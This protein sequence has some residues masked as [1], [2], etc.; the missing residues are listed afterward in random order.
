MNAR[1]IAFIGNNAWYFYL[2]RIDLARALMNRGYQVTAILPSPIEGGLLDKLQSEG[3]VVFGVPY[4]PSGMNPFREIHTVW[5]IFWLIRRLQ[6]GLVHLHTIKPVLYGGIA[7]RL[8]GVPACVLS[9]LGLGHL[10][11][12]EESS[13]TIVRTAL[14]PLFRYAFGGKHSRII[15]ENTHDAKV[16]CNHGFIPAVN[17]ARVRVISG[18]GIVLDHYPLAVRPEQPAIVLFAGR[19]TRPKGLADFVKAAHQLRHDWPEVRF[20]VCGGVFAGSPGAYD[21]SQMKAWVADCGIEWWGKREDMAAVLVRSSI[22]VLPSWYGEGFPNILIEAAAAGRP[23]VTTD[24]PGCN[25]IVHHGENGLLVPP[26][27]PDALAKAI[28]QLLDSPA[29]RARM[30]ATGRARAG[31][32]SREKVINETLKIYDQLLTSKQ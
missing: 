11:N 2:H 1:R 22:V 23:I 16:L 9:V 3:V 6:P 32:F 30:G 20:V 5:A 29:E 7:A 27:D 21:E 17:T 19:L 26:R 15:V 14:K 18:S 13:V 8:A 25:D 31:E 4:E 24:I 10:F 12:A 28:R